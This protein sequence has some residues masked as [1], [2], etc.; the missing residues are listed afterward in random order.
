MLKSFM[1]ICNLDCGG[2]LLALHLLLA[3][4]SEV[5]KP[6]HYELLFLVKCLSI[7]QPSG[8]YWSGG[9]RIAMLVY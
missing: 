1:N 7:A 4:V 9:L 8:W 6:V 3:L 5:D 2:W